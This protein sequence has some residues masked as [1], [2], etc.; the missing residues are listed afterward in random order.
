MPSAWWGV[1]GV[2]HWETLPNGCTI[3]ADLYCQQ[4]DRMA[5][6]LKG[7]Q[8]RIYFL[9]DNA[10]LH[11]VKS[12]HEK[13]LKPRWVA[14]PHPLYS[15]D[16]APT[17]YHLFRSLANHPREKKFD[18]DHHL[19]MGIANFFSQKSK[20]FYEC[21]ILSLSERWGQVIDTIGAYITES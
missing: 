10:R 12:P 1:K 11:V 5:Q 13:F 21:G 16:L 7:K 8:D 15:P 20:D 4:L 6:K 14:I 9:H 17:D 3:T 2:I 19:K 18:D